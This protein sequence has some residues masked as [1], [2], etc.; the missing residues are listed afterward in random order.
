MT[1]VAAPAEQAPGTPLTESTDPAVLRARAV[2]A[3]VGRRKSRPYLADLFKQQLDIINDPS[4]VIA[5]HP[6]RRSGKTHTVMAWLFKGMQDHPN[7]TSAYLALTRGSAKRI[8]WREMKAASHKYKLGFA[9]GEVELAVSDPL[10]GSTILLGGADDAEAIERLRG[11]KYLRAAIDECG[12]F[13]P[14]ILKALVIDIL[15]PALGDLRGQLLLTGTPSRVC[16]GFFFNVCTDATLKW[17]VHHWTVL[18]NPYFKEPA[19]YLAEERRLNHWTESHPV[20]MREWLGKWVQASETLVYQYNQVRN[21]VDAGP[22]DS[23]EIR[24][25]LGVDFGYRDSTAWS[26]WAYYANKPETWCLE[27]FKHEKLTP[28]DVAEKT[29]KLIERY[30]GFDAIV[31][32]AGGLGKGYIEEARKRFAIPFKPAEKRNK[33]GYI[34]LMNGDFQSGTIRVV[35][36]MNEDWLTEMAT[37]PWKDA[38]RN[39]EAE[40]FDNHLCFPAGTLISTCDGQV[41]ISE[42]KQGDAVLTRKGPR[43]VAAAWCTGRSELWALETEDGQCIEATGDHPFWVAGKGFTRLD[44]VLYGDSLVRLCSSSTKAAGSTDTQTPSGEAI[45]ST[46]SAAQNT[47]TESSGPRFM[48]QSHPD[49]TCTTST[50]THSTTQSRIWNAFQGRSTSRSTCGALTE[51]QN[52]KNH[53]TPLGAPPQRGMGA[54]LESHGTSHTAQGPGGAEY[55]LN[56]RAWSVAAH[57]KPEGP[58]RACA[59]VSASPSSGVTAAS[60]TSIGSADAALFFGETSTASPPT[61]LIRVRSVRRTGKLERV[62]ALSVVGEHE[63]FA[64]GLLVSNCDSSLY[65]WRECRS[66]AHVPDEK[67]P[68][69]GS[70]RW[71]KEQEDEMW[72]SH[73]PEPEHDLSWV[74]FEDD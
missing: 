21:G 16:V 62:F 50:K 14:D 20:Y 35:A 43:P 58:N 49:T 5:A 9:F 67:R 46:S 64:D 37:L 3:E 25:V 27:S 47:C 30:G 60:T 54:M 59:P 7:T 1:D 26:V 69:K 17:S 39:E 71:W 40:G 23:P 68:E 38:N 24:Y 6:G 8:M 48:G 32:D 70:A 19:E 57:T 61:A 13:A 36:R 41:P 73:A 28:S 63:Y 45:E 4:P 66:W 11:G 31:G 12:S 33:R 53:S 51:S 15:R 18:D 55:I 52:Q 34:E 72:P 65:A 56:T 22:E 10:N 44:A 42:L 74:T 2:V 29:T